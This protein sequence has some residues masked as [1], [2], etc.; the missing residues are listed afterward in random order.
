MKPKYTILK[1]GT[2]ICEYGDKMVIYPKGSG[3]APPPAH[4]QYSQPHPFAN[5]EQPLSPRE[6]L[7]KQLGLDSII[8]P[9]PPKK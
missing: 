6:L 1:S 3:V 9:H 8:Q 5:P 2:Q 7:R 4:K